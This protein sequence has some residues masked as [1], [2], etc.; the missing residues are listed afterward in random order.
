MIPVIAVPETPPRLAMRL[1]K[2]QKLSGCATIKK[3]EV[4]N[5]APAA[6]A[7]LV[8]IETTKPAA[9]SDYVDAKPLGRKPRIEAKPAEEAPLVQIE[10]KAPQA[11]PAQPAEA[12]ADVRTAAK[13]TRLR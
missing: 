9:P 13:A 10:T 2:P 1:K 11:E 6:D 7:G 3:I 4:K 5:E 12:K 8:Q